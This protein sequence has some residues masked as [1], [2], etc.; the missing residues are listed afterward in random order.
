MEFK[1]LQ[2]CR[3]NIV[4]FASLKIDKLLVLSFKKI[5]QDSNIHSRPLNSIPTLYVTTTVKINKL[6]NIEYIWS[7]LDLRLDNPL[8][9]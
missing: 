9:F 1:D 6:V 7:I 3:L 4:E 5:F 8:P 2:I